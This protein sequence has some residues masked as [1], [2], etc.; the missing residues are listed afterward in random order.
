MA[1]GSLKFKITSDFKKKLDQISKESSNAEKTMGSSIAKVGKIA[2]ATGAAVYTAVSTAV[3]FIGKASIEAFAEQEQ[4]VDGVKKLYKGAWPEVVNAAQQSY[5]TV[6]ISANQYMQQATSFSAALVSSLNDDV[7]E[8]A[9]LT[10]VAMRD[11]ADNVNVFGS[12]MQDVQNAYQGFAKQNYTMLDNLKLGYGGTK[13][14][15]ERLLRDAEAFEAQQGRHTKFTIDSFADIVKA[16]HVIQDK[17]KILGTTASEAMTTISG[18]IA[19]TKAAWED[20]LAGLADPD[21]DMSV[22]TQ[23]LLDALGNTAKLL[24]PRIAEIGRTIVE[25]L[26]AAISGLNDALYPVIAEALAAAW[27]LCIQSLNLPFPQ[28]SGSDVINGIKDT[29]QGL[30]DTIQALEPYVIGVTVAWGTFQAIVGAPAAIEAAGT[31]I[32]SLVISLTTMTDG[33]S[34]AN[35]RQAIFNTTMM[36]NPIALVIAA[37]AGLVAA[38]VWFFTQTETGRQAWAT[39]TQFL[40]DAWNVC[41]EGFMAIV[42]PVI[43]GI[44]MAWEF[45]KTSLE[46]IFTG[47]QLAWQVLCEAFNIAWLL[48]STPFLM[49]W[50]IIK[51]TVDL[52]IQ[53]LQMAWE[54]FCALLAP[55][56]EAGMVVIDAII[57]ALQTT[58]ETVVAVVQAIWEGLCAFLSPVFEVGMAVIMAVITGLQVAFE[59]VV[60]IM[61][62][63]WDG[64][65]AFFGP[66]FQGA[67]TVITA[68]INA[69][70]N[71]FSTIA[72]TIKAVWDGLGNAL[73]NIGSSIGNF[74]TSTIPSKISNAFQS[75]KD[76]AIEKFQSIKSKIKGIIDNIVGF[77]TGAN[78]TFPH[79]KLPHFSMSGEFSLA[80][81][82][83]PHIGIDWY[84]K[85]GIFSSPS[86]IGVGEAGKEAVLPLD[87]IKPYFHEAAASSPAQG[88][89]YSIG[90]VELNADS[91]SDLTTVEEFF[92]RVL[93]QVQM[94]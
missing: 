47:L 9:R 75:A 39:F 48:F 85:G 92:D 51:A 34:L 26:P 67:S 90:K 13:T 29:L 3:S 72:G 35:M 8:A 79:I 83:V 33:L 1:Q 45:L 87:K 60:G 82:S 64:L 22:L 86:V 15:M 7:Q 16:I 20:W 23:N 56:F 38:L 4:L 77:F 49:A 18:S 89:V 58:F 66:I 53:A 2:A 59:T 80:P 55:L 40:S 52:V 93:T 42:Q 84:A 74:F 73:K 27:D 17:Q 76:K 70:G 21:A 46:V 63:I 91:L 78:F 14:E 62:G 37:I 44:M 6:G 30:S 11:M 5:K 28:I 43:D 88:T 41:C 69:I 54:G 32:G 31:A 50:E 24:Q 71:I 65:C 10:D 25:N 19:M 57:T 94:A 81:P 36:Q 61:R 12:N 68:A